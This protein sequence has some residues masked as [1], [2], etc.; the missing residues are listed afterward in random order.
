MGRAHGRAQRLPGRAVVG[1]VHHRRRRDRLAVRPVPDLLLHLRAVPVRDRDGPA[2]PLPR[3]LAHRG[4]RPQRNRAAIL[5]LIDRAACPY[6]DLGATYTRADCGPLYDDLEI[7][8]GWVRNPLGTD[9]A[10][11]GLVGDRGPGG[12]AA[13]AVPSSSAAVVSGPQRA[14]DRG[15]GRRGRGRQRRR[16]RHDDRSAAGRSRCRPTR[17]PRDLTF[18]YSFA[19]DATSSRPMTLPGAAWRRR[20]GR[21]PPCSRC[22]GPPTNDDASLGGRHG[23]ARG[24]G[25]PDDPPRRRRDRRGRTAW[26]RPPWTTSASASTRRPAP[27]VL[28]ADHAAPWPP[29]PGPGGRWLALGPSVGDAREAAWATSTALRGVWNIVPTPFAP[30]G[31]R[32][33]GVDPGAGALRARRR[34]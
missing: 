34:A 19:H 23:V 28:S 24:M 13:P 33:H 5:H 17:R 6:A 2:R 20:T 29:P 9:T 32:G 4:A 16:W 31:E 18:R 8:R 30:D 14:G 27:R 12:H 3:R 22:P 1:P 10:T 21:G 26:S 7:N 15:R 11:G 25:R